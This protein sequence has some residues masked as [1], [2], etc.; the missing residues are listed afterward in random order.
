LKISPVVPEWSQQVLA[1]LSR[2]SAPR[3]LAL[4]D[5]QAAAEASTGHALGKRAAR[6]AVKAW[7][8]DGSLRKVGSSL[9]LNGLCKPRGRL[10]DALHAI[11]PEAVSSLHSVLGSTGVHNNPSVMAFAVAPSDE[12][13]GPP[14]VISTP[15]GDMRLH[16]LPRVFFEEPQG[17]SWRSSIHAYP[18]FAPEKALLDWLYLGT[19]KAASLPEPN[20]GD[21]DL[22]MLNLDK[23]G[24]WARTLGLT[25]QL[26]HWLLRHPEPTAQSRALVESE[27]SI[28]PPSRKPFPLVDGAVRKKARARGLAR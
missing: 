24:S 19:Q 16:A 25:S 9:W 28:Q 21:V 4:A 14:K 22:G 18:S 8:A 11:H 6:A 2:A 20:P 27:C 26:A 10:D 13:A 12:P 23:A 7:E 15:L 1:Y 5:V 3:A 17:E